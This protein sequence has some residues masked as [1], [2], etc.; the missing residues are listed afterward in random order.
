ML[1]DG[2]QA[3]DHWYRTCRAGGYNRWRIVYRKKENWS[4][5]KKK[6]GNWSKLVFIP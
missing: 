6:G 1:G 4:N 2:N 3:A 5:P